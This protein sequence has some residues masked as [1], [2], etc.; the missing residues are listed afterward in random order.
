MRPALG[1]SARGESWTESN[2]RCGAAG[3]SQWVVEAVGE[4][5][6]RMYQAPGLAWLERQAE[7]AEDLLAERQTAD[8]LNEGRARANH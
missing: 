8:P 1:T 4:K 7:A 3:P 2:Q 6:P 5:V